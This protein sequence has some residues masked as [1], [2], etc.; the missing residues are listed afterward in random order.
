MIIVVIIL[1]SIILIVRII[2]II[3]IILFFRDCFFQGQQAVRVLCTLQVDFVLM[4]HI[5]CIHFCLGL[6]SANAVKM[7]VTLRNIIQPIGSFP[8]F[9]QQLDKELCIFRD[10]SLKASAKG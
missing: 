5:N 4:V 9:L 3:I 8:Q 7:A 6:D 2:I 1:I 10:P